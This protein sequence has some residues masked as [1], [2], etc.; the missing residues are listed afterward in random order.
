MTE[1]ISPRQFQE[2]DGVE[3]WRVLGDDACA[4]FRTGSFEPRIAATIAAGG[5]LVTDEHAPA[6]WMLADA[7]GNEVCVSTWMGRD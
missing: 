2:A 1:W 5:H 4:Y 7:E 6:W 3:G